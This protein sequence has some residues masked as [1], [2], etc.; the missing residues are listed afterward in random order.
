MRYNA[1]DGIVVVLGRQCKLGC[2]RLGIPDVNRSV[3]R[4]GPN[5]RTHS[6]GSKD[7]GAMDA[8][9]LLE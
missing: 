9:V 5:T 3:P 8:S 6:R 1:T 2:T 4:I 7:L